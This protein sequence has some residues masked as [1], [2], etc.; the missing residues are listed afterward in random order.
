MNH[1]WRWFVVSYV[2][3]VCLCAAQRAGGEGEPVK[4]LNLA[5]KLF[6]VPR[7][8]NTATQF[9]I[10][11]PDELQA[12]IRN[13]STIEVGTL[14]RVI[15]MLDRGAPSQSESATSTVGSLFCFNVLAER[16]GLEAR[17]ELER[18]RQS[19]HLDGM[20]SLEMK[21]AIQRCERNS[22]K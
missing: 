6:E 14:A 22:K 9:K 11:I 19:I 12:E 5:K 8:P 2:A 1:A 20:V 7:D 3:A 21:T 18:I 4:V 13:L 17:G 15:L 10:V 16:G